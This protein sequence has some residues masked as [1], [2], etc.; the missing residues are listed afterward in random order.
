MAMVET[1]LSYPPHNSGSES[2]C[3]S[4]TPFSVMA[5]VGTQLSYPDQNSGSE[6]SVSESIELN[7]VVGR[8][9]TV[10]VTVSVFNSIFSHGIG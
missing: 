5:L 7:E 3:Q 2:E 1:Q 9:K 8:M 10:P 6:F 4:G